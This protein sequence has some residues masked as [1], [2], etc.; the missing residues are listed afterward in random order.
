MNEVTVE[1]PIGEEVN[2]SEY[3]TDLKKATNSLKEK[4]TRYAA[5]LLSNFVGKNEAADHLQEVFGLESRKNAKRYVKFATKVLEEKGSKVSLEES[6]D[7]GKVVHRLEM[8]Y[9]RAIS[10]GDLDL[11]IKVQ[12]MY[13]KLND[14]Y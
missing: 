13:N 10:S 5:H 11:I 14:L 3:R 7:F 4:R 9:R 12:D 8:A 1:N 2:V 6:V